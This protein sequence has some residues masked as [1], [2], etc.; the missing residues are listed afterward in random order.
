MQIH[1]A[2]NHSLLDTISAASSIKHVEEAKQQVMLQ[3][4]PPVAFT[5]GLIEKV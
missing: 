1:L 3:N 4:S 2:A 5:D